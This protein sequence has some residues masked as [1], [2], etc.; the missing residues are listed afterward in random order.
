MSEHE[1]TQKREHGDVRFRMLV[2]LLFGAGILILCAFLFLY[3]YRAAYDENTNGGFFSPSD[4]VVFLHIGAALIALLASGI[5]KAIWRRRLS[6]PMLAAVAVILPILCYQINYHSL[7]KDGPLHFTVAEGGVFHFI[8]I[9]DFDFDGVNDAYDYTGDDLREL[10]STDFCTDPY[11]IV[12]SMDYTIVGKGGNLNGSWCVH[13]TQG[14]SVYLHKSRVTYHSVKI[15][16]HL[17]EGVDAEKISA[18]VFGSKLETTV[19]NHRTVSVVLDADTCAIAQQSAA[20][21]SFRVLV[22]Y[23]LHE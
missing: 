1:K 19:E 17:A 2:T 7:K 22:C 9:H 5:L 4:G 8:T 21:E 6:W 11:G 3:R 12:E 23:V 10:S 18:S 16:L 20:E 15:T 14:I 13:G